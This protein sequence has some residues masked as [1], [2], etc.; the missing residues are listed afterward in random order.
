MI[1]IL[2]TKRYSI[3]CHHPRCLF[4]METVGR[5]LLER[6]LSTLGHDL[7]GNGAGVNANSLKLDMYLQ[8]QVLLTRKAATV[9]VPSNTLMFGIIIPPVTWSNS[10]MFLLPRGGR[11]HPVE[12]H[13]LPSLR[14]SRQMVSDAHSVNHDHRGQLRVHLRLPIHPGCCNQLRN[15]SHRCPVHRP[16]R[17]QGQRPIR[18]TR[19][20][21]R[22]RSLSPT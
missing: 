2:L 14:R 12:A 6:L 21:W 3:V 7:G 15:Q 11:W 5:R 8:H 9:L 4:H 19:N 1:S 17:Y 16:S 13:E 10:P 20:P 18:H 22:P